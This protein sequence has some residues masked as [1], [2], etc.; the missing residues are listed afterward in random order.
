MRP[1]FKDLYDSK[2]PEVW[3]TLLGN[4]L[5]TSAAVV[6]WIEGS[7][8]SGALALISYTCL[9]TVATHGTRGPYEYL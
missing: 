1:F 6:G 9:A 4:S 7:R 2:F 8:L 3:F 5:L